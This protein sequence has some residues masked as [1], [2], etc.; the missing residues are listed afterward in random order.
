MGRIIWRHLNE[1][2]YSIAWYAALFAFV[3]LPLMSLAIDVSRLLF[4]RTDLQT[5]VDAACEAAALA[6][7]AP[8]FNRTGEQRIEPGRAAQYAAQA[9]YTSATEA[10]LV[11]YQ[12]RLTTV[13]VVQPTQ[14]VCVAE[15]NVAPF[16]LLVPDLRVEV[17]A[18][19]VMRF[20]QQEP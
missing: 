7:D 20:I 1:D 8:Y 10:G 11:G 12:P 2:G 14:V 18:Q 15:A 3:L 6:A 16:I 17:A 5:S 9:F 13:S 4:V 19:S